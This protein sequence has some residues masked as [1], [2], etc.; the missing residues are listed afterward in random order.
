VGPTADR[1]ELASRFRAHGLKATPQRLAIYRALLQTFEHPSAETLFRR[2]R[3]TMP[4]LSLGTVYKTLDSLEAAQLITRLSGVEESAR[5]DAKLDPHH[6]LICTRCK[7]V[8][9][10]TVPD[11]PAPAQLGAF[12]ITGVHVQFLGHCGDCLKGERI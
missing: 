9:D 11:L 3:R 8:I 6:H 7:K 10:V 2:V 5:Y 12:E 4:S 1:A